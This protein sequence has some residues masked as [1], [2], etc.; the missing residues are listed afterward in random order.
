MSEKYLFHIDE[1]EGE[2]IDVFLSLNMKEKS[3]N[4]IQKLMAGGM[5]TVN[6][7]IVKPS[8]KLSLD[9]EVALFLP[10]PIELNIEAENIPLDIVYEDGD[11]IIINKPQGM[12]VHPAPGHY[13]G[14]VVNAL[15][16]HCRNGLSGINGELR[17]GIVHRIDKDTSGIIVAAK[18]D[19]SHQKLSG[20]FAEHSINRKYE[21]VTFNTIKEESIKIDA[22]IGRNPLNRKKMCVTDKNSK[23]AVTYITVLESFGKFTHVEARLETGRTH[24][25]RVHLS[26]MGYPILGDLVYGYKKQPFKLNGQALH[27]GLLGFIH[28]ATGEY[29]EFSSPTPDYFKDILRILRMQ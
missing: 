8:Y 26:Y 7:K 19:I 20:Q 16:Y 21:A 6:G 24:Q 12:V 23:R 9:D 28:P 22:P 25:I 29:M 4:A 3:R 27:A 17:P 15:M 5:V 18:N 14:T 10:E 13:T 1:E 11:I 2:R